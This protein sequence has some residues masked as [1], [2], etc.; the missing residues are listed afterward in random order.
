MA[1]SCEKANLHDHAETK[2]KNSI[3]DSK[4][5][6][7]NMG[8]IWGRQ[9]PGGPHFGPMKFAILVWFSEVE[10]INVFSLFLPTGVLISKLI[11]PFMSI[12]KLSKVLQVVP[13]SN[14]AK[15]STIS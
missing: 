1:A 6:G 3:P 14:I 15:L 10:E 5:H 4:I 2:Q 8:P 13:F 7:A 12:I 9:D 11:R